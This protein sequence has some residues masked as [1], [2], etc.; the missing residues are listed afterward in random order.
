MLKKVEELTKNEL[1]ELKRGITP[2]LQ[3]YKHNYIYDGVAYEM[4]LV[5]NRK[6]RK[7]DVL[8]GRVIH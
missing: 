5:W 3:G 4:I 8:I 6:T 7:N 2:L 1:D